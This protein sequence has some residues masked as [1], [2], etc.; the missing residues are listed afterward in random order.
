MNL[1]EWN[2]TEL[3]NEDVVVNDKADFNARGPHVN[4]LEKAWHLRHMPIMCQSTVEA[5]T[6]L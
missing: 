5:C 6:A 2:E 3:Y 1:K 4:A